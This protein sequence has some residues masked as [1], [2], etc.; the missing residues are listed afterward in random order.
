MNNQKIKPFTV[1]ES[2]PLLTTIS[3]HCIEHCIEEFGEYKYLYVVTKLDYEGTAYTFFEVRT[4]NRVFQV[5]DYNTAV[6]EYNR[7]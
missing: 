6:N 1:N 3:E 2:T 4:F 7:L 5:T